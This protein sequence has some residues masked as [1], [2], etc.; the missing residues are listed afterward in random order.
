VS[1]TEKRLQS[2]DATIRKILIS[3]L[4][5]CGQA[6]SLAGKLGFTITAAFGRVGRAKLRP[7]INRSYS[8]AKVVCDKLRSCL[9]WWLRLFY[10]YRPRPIP[11]SLQ[12]LPT[13][14][15]YSDGEGKYGGGGAAA[16]VPWLEHPVAVFGEVPADIRKMWA[17][18]AGIL[19]YRDIF[20]VEAIGPL[21]LL[22]TC[23]R[24]MRNA[25]WIHHVDNESAESS[26]ISGTSA[27][28]AAD[29]IVGLTMGD[30]C[31]A[32]FAS[33]LDRVESKAN[34]VDGLSRGIM[35][36]TWRNVE[37]AIF[38]EEHL[39]GLASDCDLA[40]GNDDDMP[41]ATRLACPVPDRGW[42]EVA[43]EVPAG[44]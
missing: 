5:A 29:H 13:I 39:R 28:P 15:S 27:L 42:H 23:P 10:M 9:L 31:S 14:I 26:L 37:K 7:V 18:L 12:A 3:K 32:F 19:D 20:L 34:P 36:G 21:L 30:L 6:S 43:A 17:T 16:W 1:V 44:L 8:R 22:C 4:L 25:L 40:Y 2:L 24:L 11:C 35:K 38:P 41:L 33:L